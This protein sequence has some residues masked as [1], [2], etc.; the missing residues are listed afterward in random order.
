[1]YAVA[2]RRPPALAA[3]LGGLLALNGRFYALLRSQ[4]GLALAAIGVPLHVI[5]HLV[6]V[7]AVIVGGLAHV[8]APARARRAP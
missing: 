6:A 8:L 1:M 4:G 7:A 5:H 3:A 2:R